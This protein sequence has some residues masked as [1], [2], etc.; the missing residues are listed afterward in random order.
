M[1]GC[2]LSFSQISNLIRHQRIHTGEKPFKCELCGKAFASGSNL[3]QHVQVHTFQQERVDFNCIFDGCSKTYLYQS[4][5]K[6]HYIAAHKAEYNELLRDQ[7]IGSVGFELKGKAK[8]AKVDKEDAAVVKPNATMIE[9]GL[10]QAKRENIQKVTLEKRFQIN[11]TFP[12]IEKKQKTKIE[13][14]V[15]KAY[16]EEEHES[17]QKSEEK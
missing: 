8:E 3:K 4:S 5:L 16:S 6:K 14:P 12:K 13:S 9:K 15:V 2:V 11:T 7:K 10:E 17:I 1:P